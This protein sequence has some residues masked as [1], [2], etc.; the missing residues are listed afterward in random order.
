MSWIKSIVNKIKISKEDGISLVFSIGLTLI[1]F[2]DNNYFNHTVLKGTYFIIFILLAVLLTVVMLIAGLAV[3]R[4]AIHAS[5]GFGVII[6]FAKSYC[7][8]P[9]TTTEGIQALTTLW[10]ISF[11]YILFDFARKLQEAYKTHIKKLHLEKESGL[12]QEL[13]L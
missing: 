2:L 11:I 1:V 8:L 4:A 6:F 12:L 9:T 13:F 10:T 5:V 7:E 3:Y